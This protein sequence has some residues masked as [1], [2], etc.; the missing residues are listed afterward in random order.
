MLC[1]VRLV[2]MMCVSLKQK[3]TYKNICIILAFTHT[4]HFSRLLCQ[5]PTLTQPATNIHTCT[6]ITKFIVF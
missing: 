2:S 3:Y 6:N 4:P 5:N 1:I